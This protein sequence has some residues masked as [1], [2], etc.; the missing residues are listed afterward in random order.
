MTNI[1]FMTGKIRKYFEYSIFLLINIF[2]SSSGFSALFI[3][4][5]S[6][7]LGNKI[8]Y[9]GN[10]DPIQ[11]EEWFLFC[12]IIY[13]L[14]MIIKLFFLPAIYQF[15]EQLP[16]IH[17]FLYDFVNN[18][19]KAK[20]IFLLAILFDFVVLIISSIFMS[21]MNTEEIT[22]L[23]DIIYLLG[24]SINGIVVNSITSILFLGGIFIN[25]VIFYFGY[26]LILKNRKCKR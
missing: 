22:N 5:A 14:Y 19:E 3:L 8:L 9:E 20:Q 16:H 11:N 2:F 23:S 7:Y 1:N 17:K 12:L 25:Y 18:K 15:S 21:F 24:D 26:K 4:G 10:L 13:P 6:A